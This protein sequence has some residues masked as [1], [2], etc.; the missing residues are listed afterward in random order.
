MADLPQESAW[1]AECNS[2]KGIAE[3]QNTPPLCARIISSKLATLA[4]LQTI[5]SFE[6]VY[7]LDEIATVDAY[8]S[9]LATRKK[10]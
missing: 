4:E 8:H 3:Y 5:Y 6:D 10:E 1:R 2:L 7:R 9:W